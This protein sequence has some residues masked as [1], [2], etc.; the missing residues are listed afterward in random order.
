V[1][2]QALTF[3]GIAQGFATDLV[4]G[5]LQAA[6]AE[7]VLANIGEYAGFGGIRRVMLIDAAG[8]LITP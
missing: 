8:D 5:E 3:N 7:K 4:V 1:P 6:G 2:G